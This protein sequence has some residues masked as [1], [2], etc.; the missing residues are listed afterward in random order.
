MAN[1]NDVK[2][3]EILFSPK[4][5]GS[6]VVGVIAAYAWMF[7]TFVSASDFSKHIEQF[8]QHTQ[9][10]ELDRTDDKIDLLEAQIF[11]LKDSMNHPEGNTRDRREQLSKYE[12]SL[13][14]YR[15]QQQCL[16]AGNK[17]SCRRKR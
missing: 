17:T 13:K 2:I 15:L 1:D 6:L 7:T 11:N 4:T 8:N 3:S 16:E 5:V 12:G 9:T 10:Y 14:D